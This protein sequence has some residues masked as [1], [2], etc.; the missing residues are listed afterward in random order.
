M[1]N[2][3]DFEEFLCEREIQSIWDFWNFI[4][5]GKEFKKY[6]RDQHYWEEYNDIPISLMKKNKITLNDLKD[7]ENQNQIGMQITISKDNKTVSLS[8]ED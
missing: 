6:Y 7:Y 4:D 8:T 2:N 3:K 5:N 1:E